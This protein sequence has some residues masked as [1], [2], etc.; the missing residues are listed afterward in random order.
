VQRT[1]RFSWGIPYD[2]VV[3]RATFNSG[4]SGTP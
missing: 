1:D 3:K 2:R 4:L